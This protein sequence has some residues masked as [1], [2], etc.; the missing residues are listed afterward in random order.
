MELPCRTH[1]TLLKSGSCFAGVPYFRLQVVQIDV[2]P[3]RDREADIEPLANHFLKRFVRE[4]GRK[5]KGFTPAALVKLKGYSWP[6]NVRELRNAIERAV[7][8]GSGA[9]IDVADVW[10]SPL[11]LDGDAVR[12]YEAVSLADLERQHIEKTLLHTE[13]N[14]SKAAEILGIERSTLDRKIKAYDLKK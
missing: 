9:A 13:W 4:T 3:L 7:A 5:V 2:P 14:K 12:G 11:E 6:G 10:L 8:L 1:G